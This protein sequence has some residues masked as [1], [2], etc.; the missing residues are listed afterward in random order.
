MLISSYN[1]VL[2]AFSLIVAILASYTALDMAGRVTLAKGREALSWLIGGAFAMG[3]GIWSMHFVGMLAFSLPIP[4]GY[5]LG[6]TLLSLLLAVGS[7]AFA[8]W[9][10]CQAELPWQR[11]AL[12]A[13]LM[14][15]GIA[16]M[17]YTGMAALLMM[18]GI[19]Y[20]PL[21]LGLSILI[22][23]IASGAAL[24]I[25]FRLR[26]G[27]RRIVLVRAGAA[28]VMGCAIVGMHYTGMAAAQFPLGSFCG[29]AGRGIDNGWLA[30]LVIVITLA[31]IAIALIVSV[32]DSRL[33]ARTSVL[34]TSLARANRELIQLALHDNL[35]K[36]PNRMLLDDRLEQAIQQAIRDDRRF[37]VLFMDL[38]GFKAVND[39]YGHHLGDLLLIEVAERIRANVRAQDTIARLGGDEF[40]LLIEAR[41][42]ADAA[43]LAEKLVKRISQPYQISR[44]EVRISASIGIALYPG[45]GQTRHELM[46]NADAAMYHAKDQGRNGYCF[47]ESS[48]NANAQE[49]LQLLHDLRQALERRQLVLHYQPKVL[50]PN[51]P[52]I[53]VE[54][55]LRWEH[56]Q[57]GLITP[58]QFLP[59][60]E[61]TGLIVQ[62]GEW[63]LDEACRQMRLW[64][65]GGHADWNIAVNL[66]ALQFA[67]AGLVDSVRNALLRHSLEPSHLILEVTESTAMRDADAS[68]VILEQLSAM[69][70]LRHRLLQPAVSQTPAGERTEDRPWLHQRAG[71]RQR[72]RRDRL[73][74][75]RPRPH[76]EPE[77]RR[78]GRGNRGPA[79]VPD[80]PRLQFAARLPARQA[81]A[82]R[83]VARQRRLSAASGAPRDLSEPADSPIAV[84]LT[85]ARAANTLCRARRAACRDMSRRH[86]ERLSNNEKTCMN[87]LCVLG[88]LIGL[89]GSPALAAG[90]GESGNPPATDKERFI[91]SLMARMSNAEK[92][93]QLRLVSVGTDH[94]KEALMADIRAGKVGAI[95]NTVT[96]PDI[97]AMQDQVRHSRLKIPLFHAYDVAHGHRTIFPISLG[98]AASWDP[99]VVA[100]SARIS[101]LE[102][103]ADGL[104]M[105]FS[106]MVDITRDARWGRVSEG[107]GEDTYLTSL[108]SGVMVR[109]YQGS[110]LAAPDSI[111]AAV[112]HFALY[113][114]AEGGRDYNTVDMSLPRMFQDYL[115]PYKAAV[116]AGAGAVMVSL[117]TINGVPATANRWLLTD[118]LRQQWGFK[119]LTISDHGAVKE[120]IKHGLAGNERD[121]TRLAIQAGVDMNMNDDLY[122]TWLPKLLA[123]GEIDQA[124]IDRAC[125]DVLAAKYDLGL[126][127]DPYRRLGKPDDP[128]FDTNAE[129][130]LHR[131]AA[132]EVAR[133]GL[134]LLKN[135]DGLLPLK[136]QGR[137]AVIGPLAKSQRDV[138][139]SWSAA[140]VPR[141]AVTVYQGL[142]NAVGERATLLYAKGANVSGDQAILDYL[143][144]YNPEVEVDPRSAEAMLEE[145]LRTARDA[146]LVVAVVGESQGMAHEA[147]SRTDLRIPASQRRLLK[148]LKATGKPLVL[149]LMNGR[150]L[151]LG[152]EQENA[153][154]ILETWF[155]GTEGGNAIADVL[156]GEHNPSGKLTMSFPRSVGQ[157]PVYYN[158]LNTGRPMDHDNPGK[159]TSRYFDE[160]NGPLYPFGYG[161]SYTEFSLSPLRLS[162]ERLARG[163]TLEA[164]V[165]LSNSGKRAG[166][167]V[168]QLYLQD[169]VASL[170]RPV[171]ELRGFRKVMLEPGESREIVFR[172]GEADLK[173][174]DSQL[175]H[176]AEPGE[177]KVFVGLD[178]AQTESRSFTLL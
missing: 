121:A 57:H 36:L 23:V 127:A 2:V 1:Q 122:S 53:G 91:A 20:D 89:S 154:A 168:V 66:S 158:H 80:P 174:Y 164:R 120:L 95:F 70:R 63:V 96:R 19:V 24:W 114:A 170:S 151:S 6:L 139:G 25:A 45:D 48:M 73:G 169:P 50:A 159:Y 132:R 94:P 157:V 100:R 156:F 84:S 178:S 177:F 11:L 109:A 51:G 135:R 163:A 4:L 79:G 21:W 65:D 140:G 148:A 78:R 10:V 62:I 142:A 106:P 56:P 16:A 175:R 8:L 87:R 71:P 143:N 93:G 160:A 34:A 123:A 35:T 149:V 112:K 85:S 42:P 32:L 153:D 41:E 167:T 55:L 110:N 99:E 141:Q 74:D 86:D 129:S 26:H 47:F 64:L 128:P 176:T 59:L 137:I 38:D 150:P 69:G 131:Q 44:H 146:D 67:H 72:R 124:D 15:S 76:A 172:L 116:D 134:V 152:W 126:F 39:A 90:Q 113:G 9:L 147:S 18:P 107:F 108:L 92:I 101:A 77:D 37:A 125:R 162:S 171:K 115:P 60:A 13:L 22:A 136:K 28:L 105:S 31:V 30:V 81:D 75:R 104:D 52:M 161:L 130:R 40:V 165:T 68:L 33:E 7:S 119:G 111:M 117:N 155:S 54:A 102:A 12:G 14:G 3:F 83:A 82:G 166:A 5:D 46:I 133:E 88:L 103:S 145:A 27:S 17:H 43:T 61:K 98:L 144:S 58:G 138:I 97:R 173:F 118:L 49:Q 29:A